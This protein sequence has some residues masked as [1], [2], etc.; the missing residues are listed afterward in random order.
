MCYNLFKILSIAQ[1]VGVA[2]IPSHVQIAFPCKCSTTALIKGSC[3]YGGLSG[4]ISSRPFSVCKA[5]GSYVKTEKQIIPLSPIISIRSSF[6]DSCATKHHDP[7][8]GIPDSNLKHALTVS[9]ASYSLPRLFL[10][11]SASR[12]HPKISCNRSNW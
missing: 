5:I 10:Y 9:S 3:T 12:I 1:F 2:L 6:A 8:P 11:P 4:R 7:E